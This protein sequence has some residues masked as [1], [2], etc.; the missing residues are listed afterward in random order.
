MP[1]VKALYDEDFVV[2][3]RQQAEA[4]RSA[5]H[6]GS[7]QALDWENLAEEIES[8]GRSDR[9]EL[10]SRIATIIEHLIKLGRSPAREPRQGWRQTVLRERIAIGLL[11]KDSPS[12]RREVS[13]LAASVADSA[14]RLALE[15]MHA[16]GELPDRPRRTRRSKAPLDHLPYTPEQILGDW[17]PPEPAKE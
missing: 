5:A 4:L 10:A 3:S 11:L 12:L 9:R 2:W 7:N 8:L 13:D 15:E 6:G 14:T 17:F 1:D 16:R